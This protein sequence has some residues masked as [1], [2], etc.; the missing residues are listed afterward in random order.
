MYTSSDRRVNTAIKEINLVTDAKT[1]TINL[2]TGTRRLNY[3]II[4]K[5][6]LFG[7]KINKT[8]K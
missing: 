8:D 3:G 2:Q 5:K 4:K 7:V 1:N 6:L